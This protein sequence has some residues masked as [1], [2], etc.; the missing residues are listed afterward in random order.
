LKPIASL[1]NLENKLDGQESTDFKTYQRAYM[2]FALLVILWLFIPM[3][4][5]NDYDPGR[6]PVDATTWLINNK[7]DGLGFN[8]DNWG[9]YLYWRREKPVFIDDKGDFYTTDFD[10]EYVTVYTAGQGW[11]KV[12]EKYKVAWLMLPHGWP[13]TAILSHDPRWKAVYQDN[14]VTIFAHQK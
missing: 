10:K 13:L 4:K 5:I 1:F 3:F 14:L 7:F 9:D 2:L 8:S 11:Q 12:L 6:I